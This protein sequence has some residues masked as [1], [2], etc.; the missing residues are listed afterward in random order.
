MHRHILHSKIHA[1]TQICILYQMAQ[2]HIFQ[3]R[4]FQIRVCWNCA[5]EMMTRV[6]DAHTYIYMHS[7]FYYT[8]TLT[9]KVACAIPDDK[10][11][12]TNSCQRHVPTFQ[13]LYITF[14]MF[15]SRG[16]QTTSHPITSQRQFLLHLHNMNRCIYYMYACTYAYAFCTATRIH[17]TVTLSRCSPIRLAHSL[18]HRP[19]Y[20][21]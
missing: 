15:S 16:R 5:T 2:G 19:V 8:S 10:L 18:M 17:T 6:T 14:T 3:I 7:L 4:C 9:I 21:T 20:Y 13:S 12:S 1:M 11:S